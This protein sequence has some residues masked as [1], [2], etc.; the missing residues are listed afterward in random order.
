MAIGREVDPLAAPAL[1][2]VVL[3]RVL[4]ARASRVNLQIAGFHTVPKVCP[5]RRSTTREK[6]AQS[7]S[8]MAAFSNAFTAKWGCSEITQSL[9]S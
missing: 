8:K 6:I 7:G 3:E 5:A 2:A 4:Q 9:V 1:A